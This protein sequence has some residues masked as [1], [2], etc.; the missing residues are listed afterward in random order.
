MPELKETVSAAEIIRNFGFWQQQALTKPLTITHH[1]RA[2]V[3]LVSRDEYERMRL[4]PSAAGA[5]TASPDENLLRSAAMVDNMAEAFV[6]YDENLGIR[7]V[8]RAMEAY[9]G[10]PRHELIGKTVAEAVGRPTSEVANGILKR[11]LRTGESADFEFT[12]SIFPGRTM[13]VHAFPFMGCIAV[14]ST[15]I[16]EQE[17]WRSSDAEW[18]ACHQAM[19]QLKDTGVARL[20]TRGRVE[21]ADA[22]FEQMTGFG[23]AQL[24]DVRLFDIIDHANRRRAQAMFEKVISERQPGAINV[25][26]I[27][28]SGAERPANLAMAPLTRDFAATGVMLLM[29]EADAGAA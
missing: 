23:A 12:S 22:S 29:R 21:S 11:V 24:A 8:N 18:Q 17:R 19:L 13:K 27:A 20:D 4:A 15:N 16:T 7:E 2:R 26:V 9:L 6:L 28:K 1:G 10:L 14:L 25:K 3:M 5:H